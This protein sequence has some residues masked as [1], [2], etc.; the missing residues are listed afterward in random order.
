MFQWLRR[1]R[2]ASDLALT[3]ADENEKL[4]AVNADLRAAGEIMRRR[5]AG[6]DESMEVLRV[7]IERLGFIQEKYRQ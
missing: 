1:M 6:Q 7:A 4:R 3:L 5:L 2:E